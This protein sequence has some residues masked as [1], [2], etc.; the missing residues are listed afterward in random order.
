MGL[1]G[2]L[3]FWFGEPDS[4]TPAFIRDAAKQALDS[5][6]T[7]Y[8]HNLGTPSLRAALSD[9]LGS[10]HRP[11]P[12]DRIV[13]T[14]SGVSGLML[15]AQCILSPGDR[16]V[17]V[18]PVWPNLAEIPRI[19]GAR[20]ERIPVTLNRQRHWELDLDRLIDSLD[21][22]VRALI[23]NSPNNPTGWILPQQ[24]MRILLEHCRRHGIWI[25]SD[26]AYQRLT[27]DGSYHAPSMLDIAEPDDRLI[28]ANTFSKAW[29]M[30]GW[31][32]GWLTVPPSLTD[33]VGKLVEF[34]TSCAPGFVQH[35]AVAALRDGEPVV[36]SFVSELGR[37]RDALLERLRGIEAIEAGIPDG[38]MYVFLRV[39][40]EPDSLA[41]AKR[42][43]REAGIGL[44]PGS[45][46]GE[47]SEG[48]LRWCFARPISVLNEAA[49]RLEKA[50]GNR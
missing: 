38:A 14:S 2:V 36:R 8:H 34:N 23:V 25:I 7:F 27:F 49:D 13:V 1:P 21:A 20:V 45:A 37:R 11:T 41:F 24:G 22:G 35:A 9:Y 3:P 15:A 12:T 50:L 40:G 29:Q 18:T 31:R 4:V 26:E 19:L 39:S 32:L 46:F 28:V 43:V 44:A 6:D 16:V 48:W 30:T 47:E 42:L 17:A 10:L 5:G 33:D